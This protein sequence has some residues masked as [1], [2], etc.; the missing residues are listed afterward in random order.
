MMRRGAMRDFDFISS[1]QMRKHPYYQEFLR[2]ARL[3]YFS[4]VKM[5]A[6]DD[7]WCVS[8]QRSPDQGPFSPDQMRR[9]ASLSTKLASAGALA[10]ALGFATANAVMET[11][12][13]TRSAVAL[14][15]RSFV[16]VRITCSTKTF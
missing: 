2:P 16:G 5:A 15:D 4:G 11:F 3:Q 9:L 7:V 6:G 13:L 8:V 12:E 10:R 1:D 14:L